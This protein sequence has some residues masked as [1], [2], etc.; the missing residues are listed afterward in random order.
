VGEIFKPHTRTGR[1]L[2]PI[3]HPLPQILE[4]HLRRRLER[5]RGFTLVCNICGQEFRDPV[6]AWIHQEKTGH[7]CFQLRPEIV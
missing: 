4:E 5:A 1:D 3:R 2:I 6:E 7:R